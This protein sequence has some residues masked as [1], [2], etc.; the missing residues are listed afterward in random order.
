[1]QARDLCFWLQGYF[2]LNGV[3][4]VPASTMQTISDHLAL[5]FQHDAGIK[6]AEMAHPAPTPTHVEVNPPA[7]KFLGA[8]MYC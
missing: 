2:E 1:M 6:K 4:E 8:T 5:V 3:G 7:L